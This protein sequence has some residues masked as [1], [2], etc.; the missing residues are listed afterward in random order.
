MDEQHGLT[1]EKPKGLRLFIRPMLLIAGLLSLPFLLTLHKSPLGLTFLV[2]LVIA[3]VVTHLI[4]QRAK[5]AVPLNPAELTA[6]AQRASSAQISETATAAL[7]ARDKQDLEQFEKALIAANAKPS[8]LHILLSPFYVILG[9]MLIGAIV[10]IGGA[11]YVLL[12]LGTLLPLAIILVQRHKQGRSTRSLQELNLAYKELL[13]K[14]AA[15]QCHSPN[16]SNH[17]A[18]QNGSGW[19]S[20]AEYVIWFL[21]ACILMRYL[22]DAMLWLFTN[23]S[24]KNSAQA[25]L[26]NALSFFLAFIFTQPYIHIQQ[27]FHPHKTRLRIVINIS[28]VTAMVLWLLF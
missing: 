17:T 24:A 28:L 3:G 23:G 27:D 25:F 22:N 19:L 5:N 26:F 6:D 21:L 10:A 1:T 7:A 16:N 8:L 4:K 20:T 13:A 2:L 12:I 15:M 18:A 14:M 9:L 11:A